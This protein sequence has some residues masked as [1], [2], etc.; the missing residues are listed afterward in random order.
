VA[1]ST[2]TRCTLPCIS[3]TV[4]P[5][6][7]S[8]YHLCSAPC[9]HTALPSVRPSDHPHG[10]LVGTTQHY[11]TFCVAS[12]PVDVSDGGQLRVLAIDCLNSNDLLPLPSDCLRLRLSG[13]RSYDVILSQRIVIVARLQY[14]VL[15]VCSTFLCTEPGSPVSV[16]S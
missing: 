1:L 14:S 4:G 12:Y 10:Y 16:I 11:S 2:W 5:Q 15:H 7:N 9:F 3:C 13:Y 6:S 8:T